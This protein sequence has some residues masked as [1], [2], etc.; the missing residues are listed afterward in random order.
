MGLYHRLLSHIPNQHVLH[1]EES[2]PEHG[3]KDHCSL[4]VPPVDLFP[5]P[6][7]PV[8]LYSIRAFINF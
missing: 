2:T 3:R 5:D 4:G 1:C 6:L 7:T 8:V